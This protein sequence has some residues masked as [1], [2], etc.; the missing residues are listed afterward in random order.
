MQIRAGYRGVVETLQRA[1]RA[2]NHTTDMAQ[3]T[4][5]RICMSQPCDVLSLP[6]RYVVEIIHVRRVMRFGRHLC[7]CRDCSDN[8]DECPM[9]R[10][11]IV[12]LIV[13][14]VG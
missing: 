9:C 14:Y 5:C 1:A 10:A 6:C 11:P 7:M 4:L 12:R 13:V 8:V 3:R 2:V